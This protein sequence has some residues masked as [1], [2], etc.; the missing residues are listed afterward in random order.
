MFPNTI[1]VYFES[2]SQEASLIF[3]LSPNSNWMPLYFSES[4]GA[5]GH[6][7]ANQSW[8]VMDMNV[9]HHHPRTTK[10]HSHVVSTWRGMEQE[11]MFHYIPTHTT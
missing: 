3:T 5:G 11:P 2:L 10:T 7:Y 8:I 4:L 9:G 1:L 6:R